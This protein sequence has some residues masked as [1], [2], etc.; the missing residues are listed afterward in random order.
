MKIGPSNT[1]SIG[2][3]S[4]KHRAQATILQGG[5]RQARS[6][7]SINRGAI[8]AA[9]KGTPQTSF[10]GCCSIRKE[11]GALIASLATTADKACNIDGYRCLSQYLSGGRTRAKKVFNRPTCTTKC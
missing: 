8:E 3:K 11:K 5:R 1:R 6:A 2:P 4:S 7:T 9:K 10:P